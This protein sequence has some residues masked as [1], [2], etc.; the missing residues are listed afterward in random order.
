M[1][2]LQDLANEISGYAKKNIT[3]EIINFQ[4][5]AQYGGEWD[6]GDVGSCQIKISN[7]GNLDVKNL[8]LHAN[9]LGGY[10]KIRWVAFLGWGSTGWE[11]H[12]DIAPVLFG[13]I[14][15]GESR[16]ALGYLGFRADHHT[17][18]Q[19]K[20]LFEVHVAEYDVSLD[21][22]LYDE[23]KHEWATQATQKGKIDPL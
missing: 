10:G 4:P 16:L 7:N 2:V 3:I 23:T 13:T 21:S 8:R 17:S 18:E 6:E 1:S 11:V 9:R 19:V 14:P 22:L 15:A 12:L 5:Y 20:D